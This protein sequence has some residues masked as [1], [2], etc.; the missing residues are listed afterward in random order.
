[1]EV[2]FN[3]LFLLEQITY[4]MIVYHLPQCDINTHSPATISTPVQ[5]LVNLIGQSNG[6][7][8]MHLGI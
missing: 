6:S 1:M 3:A 4:F 5:L 8:S 7:N 2:S